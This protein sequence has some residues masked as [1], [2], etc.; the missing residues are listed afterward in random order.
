[1]REDVSEFA[2][3]SATLW[4]QREALELLLFKLTEEQLVV[5]GGHRRWLPSADAELRDAVQAFR[6]GEVGRAIAVE[7]L[8][9]NCGLPPETTL[10]QLAEAAP[11]PWDTLLLDHHTALCQL[12]ADVRAVAAETTHLLD[13][14]A[15]ALRETLANVGALTRLYRAE[16]SR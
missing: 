9:T 13:A 5:A 2:E 8:A 12:A 10:R 14:C 16:G 1:M 11:P 15:R 7:A 4:G 6:L 3:L